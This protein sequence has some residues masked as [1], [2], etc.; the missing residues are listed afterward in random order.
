MSV[1]LSASLALLFFFSNGQLLKGMTCERIHRMDEDFLIENL[2]AFKR[3]YH[4]LSPFQV[5][6]MVYHFTR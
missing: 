3:S 4:L 6:R 5:L 1:C 2:P